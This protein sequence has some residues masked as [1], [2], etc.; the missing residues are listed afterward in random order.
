VREQIVAIA[1]E[2]PELSPRQLAT[3][4]TDAEDYFVS[5]ASDFAAAALASPRPQCFDS[6]RSVNDVNDPKPKW[7]KPDS[8]CRHSVSARNPW[9]NA[10]ELEKTVGFGHVVVC[11]F[12]SSPFIANELTAMIGVA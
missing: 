12:S 2:M 5:Q 4:F 7:L 6:G 10:Q 1:L 9:M 11:A 8:V 3:R